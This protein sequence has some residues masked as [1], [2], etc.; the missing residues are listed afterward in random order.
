V[1]STPAHCK[2]IL[3]ELTRRLVN[4][5]NAK[6]IGDLICMDAGET[7]AT[8]MAGD[9]PDPAAF[10]KNVGDVI[11]Q[12]LRG[13]RR[14]PVRAYGEM[15]DVLW[16][17][18]KVEAAIKLEILWNE[19]AQTHS[20]QLLCGYSMGSFYKQAEYFERVCHQHTHVM[21]D[22]MIGPFERRTIRRTA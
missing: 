10:N 6:R 20:F 17:Q 2:A 7:L 13:R 16:K 5:E 21:T 15:V 3:D 9:V 22:T 19:L 11:A 14:T 12:T 4:V 8:F 1:I 18:G